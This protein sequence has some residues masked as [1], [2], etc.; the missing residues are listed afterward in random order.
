[1]NGDEL[2]ALLD[3][4]ADTEAT[5]SHKALPVLV[6][7]VIAEYLQPPIGNFLDGRF[8]FECVEIYLLR[9]SKSLFVSH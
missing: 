6:V 5:G 2:I 7:S 1:M 3:V 8:L 9:F 4:A